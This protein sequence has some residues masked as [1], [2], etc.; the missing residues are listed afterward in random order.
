MRKKKS[1][2]VEITFYSGKCAK[3]ITVLGKEARTVAKLLERDTSVLGYST[4][5]PFQVNQSEISIVGIRPSYLSE[6]WVTDFCVEC[7]DGSKFALEVAAKESMKKRAEIEKL[8]LSRRFWKSRG[9]KWKVA[10]V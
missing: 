9:I 5:I 7:A 6:N 1:M 8:E 4:M 10:V 3:N 2:T